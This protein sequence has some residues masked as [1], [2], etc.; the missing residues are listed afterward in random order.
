MFKLKL[1]KHRSGTVGQ[2]YPTGGRKKG[3]I[4]PH[5]I[6]GICAFYAEQRPPNGVKKEKKKKK[7]F[8]WSACWISQVGES[9]DGHSFSL[10]QRRMIY[11]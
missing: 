8:P 6:Q 3:E 11:S 2:M 1:H 7:R 4:P 5:L 10:K 9:R